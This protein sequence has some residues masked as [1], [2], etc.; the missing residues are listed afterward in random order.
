M[1]LMSKVPRRRLA[2]RVGVASVLVAAVVYAGAHAGGSSRPLPD[3][4]AAR[5]ATPPPATMSV[6]WHRNVGATHSPLVERML[7]GRPGASGTR[8]IRT[9]VPAGDALGV[10]VS[11]FDH[12]AGAPIDW[13]KVAAAGYKFA[14]IKATE[15]SYYQNPYYAS[16]AAAARKAGLFTAAYHFAIP[17]NSSGTL[18]ADLAVD[19]AGDPASGGTTLPLI[20][21]AEYDPYVSFDG[22]NECYGLSAATMVAWIGSFIAEVIRRT[23]QPP[24]IYTTSDWWDKCTGNSSAFGADPLWIASSVKPASVPRSW[25]AFTYWQFTSAATVPGIGVSTDAS[26]FSPATLAAAEPARKSDAAGASVRLPV[27]SLAGSAGNTISY[28]ATGLPAGLAIDPDTGLISGALPGNPARYRV[29]LTLTGAKAQ[30]QTLT[31]AWQVHGPVRL[32]WPGRQADRAGSAVSLQ[33]TADDSLTGCSLRFTASGLP[34][35]LAIGTCGR[36]TGL[37]YRPGSYQATVTAGD[38]ASRSLVSR[39]FRWTITSPPVIAAGRMRLALGGAV[40]CLADLRG[41]AGPTAKVWACGRSSGQRWSLTENG[42]IEQA[43]KCLAAVTLADGTPAI[44]LRSC[45]NRVAQIWQQVAQGGLASAKTGQCLS[46]PKT[47]PPDGTAVTLAGCAGIARQ[48]WTLPPG[49]LAP[50]IPGQCLAKVSAAGGKPAHV[51]LTRCRAV[52][53]QNWVITPAGAIQ[54]G[55]RCLDAGPT[56]A[57]GTPVTLTTCAA[58]SGQ[59]WQPLPALATTAST[60]ASTTGS[61]GT[62]LVNPAAGL[63]LDVAAAGTAT[64]PL[65]LAYCAIDHPRLTWRTS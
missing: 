13:V 43:G 61:T 21:D 63:C 44:G 42:S 55:S 11:S 36:I 6:A 10:D 8:A 34:P 64:S 38:S 37:P 14:F 24:V 4:L 51:M 16:D 54:F 45:T 52:A 20:L 22:T 58:G 27:R 9:S 57:A 5:V 49:P 12:P 40:T 2:G 62:L 33:L 28:G 29:T 7:A 41:S 47:S 15:G 17:N 50:D 39:T 32:V 56:A 25:T 1:E 31:F 30:A 53:S 65:T 59:Q 48:A 19:A 3:A 35:G 18:Q 60:V 46:E 26:Y 23:G